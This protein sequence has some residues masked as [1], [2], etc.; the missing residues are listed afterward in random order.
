MATT[1]SA[2]HDIGIAN[3]IGK[4]SDAIE[5]THPARL[6]FISGTPGLTPAGDLP[7]DFEQQAEQAWRNV[8]QLLERAGMGPEHLVKIVQYLVRPA[9]LPAYGA[10]RARILGGNRPASMLLVVAALPRPDFLI[11]IEAYAAA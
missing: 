2:I 6:L 9:D 1:A 4:Y 5:V 8:L 11:E 10:V 3:Q 7:A